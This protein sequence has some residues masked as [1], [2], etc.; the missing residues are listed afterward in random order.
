M[1]SAFSFP[2]KYIKLKTKPLQICV[3]CTV[4]SGIGGEKPEHVG[5]MT[6]RLVHGR[7]LIRVRL[8]A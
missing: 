2:R 8:G 1:K 5:V 4:V 7:M 3:Q 6:E